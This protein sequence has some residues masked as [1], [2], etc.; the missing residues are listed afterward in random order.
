MILSLLR[1]NPSKSTIEALYGVIVAQ[2]RLPSFYLRYGVPD[3]VDGRFD[4]IVLHLVLLNGRISAEPARFGAL[5]RALFDRFCVDLD[6]NLREMGVGDLTV[7]RRMKGYAEAFL[8]RG[9]AYRGALSANDTAALS[10]ALARNVY[11]RDAVDDASVL[12]A[13]YV[14]A[15]ASA[16]SGT[17]A[18]AILTGRV[19]LP[20]PE[21]I[22]QRPDSAAR[23]E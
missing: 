5:E 3:T 23:V 15:A 14:E 6:H 10:S 21:T 18:D 8:G 13:D 22:T 2:A 9:A 1:R 17:A 19:I 7:P 20:D 11:G 4:M 12:L 16:L